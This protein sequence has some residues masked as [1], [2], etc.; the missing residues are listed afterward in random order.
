MFP[1][2]PDPLICVSGSHAD[3]TETTPLLPVL[4]NSYNHIALFFIG[5]LALHEPHPLFLGFAGLCRKFSSLR[6]VMI[7]RFYRFG[8]L[9]KPDWADDD[10]L[11]LAA[12]S[13]R[14]EASC[15]LNG[16]NEMGLVIVRPDGYVAYSAKVD[17]GGKEL[18]GTQ[19]W[20]E[21]VLL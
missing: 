18:L 3:L 2:A 9:R 15:G 12:S 6:P 11:F 14:T 4:L 1:D 16:R 13:S 7:A 8:G 21:Q 17:A 10:I 20:L 5:D 19:L